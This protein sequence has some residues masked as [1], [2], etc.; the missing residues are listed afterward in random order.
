MAYLLRSM[1]VI[2]VI[3]WNSPVFSERSPVPADQAAAKTAP[4]R[5]PVPARTAAPRGLDIATLAAGG[6]A[7]REALEILSNLDPETRT[8]LIELGL[9]TTAP[10]R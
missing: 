5:P 4:A 7:T 3:A 10:P 6:T 9:R 1:A 8:R 2:G